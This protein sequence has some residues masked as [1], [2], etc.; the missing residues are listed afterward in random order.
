M[1]YLIFNFWSAALLVLV[2][3]WRMSRA[4]EWLFWIIVFCVITILPSL[5]YGVGYDYFNYLEIFND[6]DVLSV[7][8]RKEEYGFYYLVLVLRE[9]GFAPQSLFFAASA[10]SSAA[11][12]FC[13]RVLSGHGYKVAIVFICFFLITGMMHNQMNG[14]RNYLA[15]YFFV[16]AM[17]S[18]FSNKFGLTILFS[19]FGLLFHQTFYAVAVFLLVPN[20]VYEFLSKR[21]L[22]FYF[23]F[24]AFWLSG[25]AMF[26]LEYMLGGYLSFYAHYAQYLSAGSSFFNVLTKLYYVPVHLWF[27]WYVRKSIPEFAR[28]ELRLVGVWLLGSSLYL[29]LLHTELFY[30]AY[31]YFVFFSLIPSYYFL[32]YKYSKFVKFLFFLYIVI[33]YLAKVVAFPVGEYAY[34]SIIFR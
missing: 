34:S 17:L 8:F 18:K 23:L 31:H 7:Y 2:D 15:A 25:A 29:S 6:D 11:I 26:L 33:P 19:L 16:C 20:F 27:L 14:V 5:Q 12:V 4:G 30:R 10:L 22:L 28:F 32:V 24:F 13:L 9:L 3:N 21:V 1:I